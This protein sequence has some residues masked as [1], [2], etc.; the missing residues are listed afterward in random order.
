MPISNLGF[1]NPAYKPVPV[2]VPVPMF[3]PLRSLRDRGV[4]KKDVKA[5]S[6]PT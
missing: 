3:L 4:I 1:E 6:C 2:P 5:K